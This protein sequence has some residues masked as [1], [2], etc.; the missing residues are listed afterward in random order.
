MG[1]LPLTE[2]SEISENVGMRK[3]CLTVLL[4]ASPVLADGA[5]FIVGYALMWILVSLF[6]VFL[7]IKALLRIPT[8]RN[9][10]SDQ[11]QAQPD[12]D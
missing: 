12:E 5:P 7:A 8:D 2:A 6:I 4:L 11:G 3:I 9:S 10:G 1:R